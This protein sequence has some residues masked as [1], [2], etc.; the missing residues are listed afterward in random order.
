[1]RIVCSVDESTAARD[2]AEIAGQVAHRMRAELVYVHSVTGESSDG[3]ALPT[4]AATS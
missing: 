4:G 2:A 3:S 1:M